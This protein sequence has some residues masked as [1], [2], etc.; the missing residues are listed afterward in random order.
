MLLALI[1]FC[2]CFSHDSKAV[3]TDVY[4]FGAFPH[5]PPMR[6]E[7]KYAPLAIAFG[8][9]LNKRIKLGTASNFEKFQQR[10]LRGDFDIALI[11]PLDIVA[12]VDEAGYIP[13]ARKKSHPASIVVPDDSPVKKVSDLQG[14]ILGLPESTPVNI[15]LQLSLRDQGFT[16][17]KTIHIKLFKNVQACL[18]KMILKSVDACG[19]ASGIVLNRFQQKMGKTLRSI[20]ETESFPHMLFVAHPDLSKSERKVLS[21]SLLGRNKTQIG[22]N[23]LRE[24][25]GESRF[26]PYKSNDYNVIRQ[27][28]VRWNNHAN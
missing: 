20:M 27:Y 1:L 7:K 18:H 3:E 2:S 23:I 4:K 21:D 26:V 22:E 12:V 15:I 5:M 8:E 10:V 19:S 24:I 17:D 25:G 13:L 6:I 9:L 11:P 16:Q 28:L 14:K